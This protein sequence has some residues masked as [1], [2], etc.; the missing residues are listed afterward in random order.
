[1][2]EDAKEKGTRKVG[3]A[4]K[5]KRKGERACNHL[6]Y[7]PLPPTFGTFEIIRFQ[8]PNCWNVN[9]LESFSRDYFSRRALI[10]YASQ[11][12]LRCKKRVVRKHMTFTLCQSASC[13]SEYFLLQLFALW[14]NY[15]IFAACFILRGSDTHIDFLRL[16]FLVG[17]IDDLPSDA[18]AFS[19]TSLKRRFLNAVRWGF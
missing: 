13:S 12:D 14:A 1:M 11:S 4:K 16:F 9:E 5:R 19:L 2:G 18:R 6:F 7:D 15:V 17:M 8:L 3:G 10:P